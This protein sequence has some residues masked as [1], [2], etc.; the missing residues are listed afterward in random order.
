[1]RIFTAG[2]GSP[3]V[4]VPGIHGRWEYLKPVVDALAASFRVITFSLA[5]EP[6][7]NGPFDAAH[8]MDSYVE[9]IAQAM[10][11]AGV[12][13]AAVCGVSFGGLIA[14]RFAAERPARVTALVLASTPGPR[15]TLDPSFQAYAA[16]PTLSAPLFF[17]GVPGRVRAELKAALPRARDRAKFAWDTARTF[18]HA[19]VS[20]TRMAARA[21]AIEPHHLAIDAATIRVPTLVIVGEESLDKLVPAAGSAEYARIVPGAVLRRLERTGHQGSLTRPREFAAAITDFLSGLHHAAA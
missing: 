20:P 8:V 19:P 21:L 14:L 9:Q 15:W 10:D 4:V 18:L 3:L 2:T 6:G 5:D 12:V 1:M 13:A 7:A 16:R 17:A 11:Q